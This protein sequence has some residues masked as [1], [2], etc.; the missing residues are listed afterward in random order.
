MISVVSSL[1]ILAI[2]VVIPIIGVEVFEW[3]STFAI[4]IPYAAG[5]IF[6]LGML[7]RMFRWAKSYVPF[8]VPTT[9]GQQKSLPWIKHDQLENPSGTIAVMGRMFLEIFLFRSLFRNQRF[10]LEEGRKRLRF[11]GTRLLWLAGMVF[12]WSLLIIIIRHSRLFMEWDPGLNVVDVIRD[13]DALPQVVFS[14]LYITNVLIIAAVTF[15]FFRRVVQPQMRYISLL[16]D[17]FALL[18]I[19]SVAVSGII[20]R[21]FFNDDAFL[22]NVKVLA[23]SVLRFDPVTLAPGDLG[24]A[25]YVHITLFC[26]LLIYFPFSKMVHLGG[27]FLSPTRNQANTNRA[28]R[29]VNPWDYQVKM[30]PY[31]EYEDEFRA[32]MKESGLPLDK[33]S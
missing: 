19:A 31:E 30:H 1:F 18:L 3:Q 32:H 6:L 21:W 12:H 29:H 17:Y 8:R 10:E 4:Y 9:C 22:V 7:Y 2:L 26:A 15:L 23:M 5:G 16:S 28:K 25:F 27:V 14:V 11:D 33:E 13:F 20:M 24:L